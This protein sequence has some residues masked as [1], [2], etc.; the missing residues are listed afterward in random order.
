M[1]DI[2]FSTRDGF[3]RDE[4]FAFDPRLERVVWLQGLDASGEY[5]F[6][7]DGP[8]TAPLFR[9]AILC[10]V[11]GQFLAAIAL[12]FSVIERSIAARFNEVKQ[13]KDAKLRAEQLLKKAQ[14]QGWLS[15]IER[16]N[17]ERVRNLRNSIAHFKDPDDSTAMDMRGLMSGKDAY[18][19]LEK[20]AKNV[21]RA[22]AHIL[23]KTGI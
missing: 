3:R 9:E 8:L 16:A 10:F 11:N 19:A 22:A 15:E 12:G 1:K 13:P 17:L 7:Q 14:E 23:G 21:L 6:V 18:A 4:L 20:H 2:D 5:Y